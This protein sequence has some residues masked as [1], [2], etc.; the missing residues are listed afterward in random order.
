MRVV[1]G[2]IGRAHGIRGDVTVDP[3]TDEP[4]R[5]FAPGSSVLCRGGELTITAS[6]EHSGRLLVTFAEVP[7]R[8]AA[9]GLHGAI[10]EVEVDPDEIPED[11]DA[12]YDRQL[13]GLSVVV[14]GETIGTVV[15]VLHLPAHD[16][17]VLDLD[18]RTVQ[19]PFVEA[20]VPEVDLE[21]GT[22]TVEDRPGLL[23]PEEADEVR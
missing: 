11:E 2:R 21:A 17:L 14:A 6:R 19:V 8:T 10:L 18:G 15:E 16:T 5:R 1:V 23:N 22:V 20:L 13:L 9:E 4:D 12:Y 3:R 7:D